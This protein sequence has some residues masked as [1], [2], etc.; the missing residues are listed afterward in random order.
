[1]NLVR[2]N[3][4]DVRTTNYV[5]HPS[6][7]N[8]FWAN[9]SAGR[10]H[11]YLA[12]C[13]EVFNIVLVGSP[14][15]ETDFYAIPYSVIKP[16]L[17]EKYRTPDQ[18]DRLRW[19]VSVHNHQLRV[20]KFPEAVDVSSYY[21]KNFAHGSAEHALLSHSYKNDYAIENCRKEIQQRSKQSLFRKRVSD[22]FQRTCCLSGIKEDSLLVAS[23]I[24]PWS[25]RTDTRLDPG[26]GLYLFTLY[27][28]LFDKGFISF[29]NDLYVIVTP[30]TDKLS[31]S[32][33]KIITQ[34][35][36]QRARRPQKW[37][38]NPEYLQYHRQNVFQH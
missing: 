6:P 18:N 14:D 1:M 11:K 35:D 2:R 19:V 13:G 8:N 22:N 10:I 16:A 31:V 28:Q 30:I 5:L 38:I 21:G 4:D 17:T 36:G 12:K 37:R 29:T 33:R 20:G 24:I 3:E 9:I 32:L 26:N 34:L 7:S 23:H 25:E 15:D 27:D